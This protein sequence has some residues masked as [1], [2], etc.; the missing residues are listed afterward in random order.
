MVFADETGSIVTIAA[1]TTPDTYP[2]T[3]HPTKPAKY[4]LE[5]PAGFSSAHGIAVGQKIVVQ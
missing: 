3:F 5:L 4:V 1:N 2:Q